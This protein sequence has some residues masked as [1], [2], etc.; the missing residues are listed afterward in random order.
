MMVFFNNNLPK[1]SF[2]DL[3]NDRSY[4]IS[5]KQKRLKLLRRCLVLGSVATLIFLAVTD[6]NSLSLIQVAIAIMII[7]VFLISFII[8]FYSN[9]YDWILNFI[10]S[11]VI[12][13]T[14]ASYYTDMAAR[15]ILLAPLT[16]LAS[17]LLSS[18]FCGAVWTIILS[19]LTTVV[20]F[21]DTFNIYNTKL[22]T[23][24]LIYGVV[25]TVMLS[26]IMYLY[27]GITNENKQIIASRDKE[28][29][30]LNQK[31]KL[32]LLSNKNSSEELARTL[33]STQENIQLLTNTKRAVLNILEDTNELQHQLKL[34]KEGVEQTVQDRTV[35][36]SQEQARLK[37]SIHSL[38]S[39]FLMTFQDDQNAIFNPALCKLL[40]IDILDYKKSSFKTSVFIKLVQE[41]LSKSFNLDSA[42]KISQDKSEPFMADNILVGDK[43]ISISGAPIT[44][45]ESNAAIGC[46]I[47]MTD[48]TSENMLERSKDEFISI[49]SHELRTPLTAI[50]GNA[51]MLAMMY[52]DKMPNDD[53]RMMLA[54]IKDS[55][56]RLIS[57]VNQFLDTSRLEQKRAIFDNKPLSL[58]KCILYCTN[59][60]GGMI[61]EK[62][63]TLELNIPKDLP[64]VMAD[65]IRTQEIIIN[66]LGNAIKYTDKG[67]ITI[68]AHKIDGFVQVDFKDTGKG[69]DPKF[70]D[71]LFHKFQQ[72]SEDIL[73]RD[74]SRS[75]GLGLYIT[76]LLIEQMGGKIYLSESALGKGSTFTITL[77]I[78]RK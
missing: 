57:I 30:D 29:S 69:I 7:S 42:I 6:I 21:L 46:V 63:L 51:S 65:E 20:Y 68:N 15:S 4:D 76:M 44:M 60:L 35:Q 3:I 59:E 47:L 11:S 34:E 12:L 72:I 17:Y 56:V 18:R 40:G 33:E 58:E 39:G 50:R 45:E 22:D 74:N 24:Q 78:A 41:K 70:S 9:K 64:N 53:A 54:D 23:N 27:T 8:S 71:Q 67:S 37:A 31:L 52:N 16:I 49:A 62:A 36:L 19:A 61:K 75:T 55:S 1:I 25:S 43:Y 26:V 66:V 28:L 13:S 38:K 73:T 77:P 5:Y 10:I 2:T 32:Q 48:K 14:V